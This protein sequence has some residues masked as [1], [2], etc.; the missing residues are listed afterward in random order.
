MRAA[1]SGCWF[2]AMK[3]A[4]CSLCE[5]VGGI[6]VLQT[7]EFRVIR[8]E[9]TDFPAFYRLVWNAHVAEWSDLQPAERARC[10]E[11]VATVERAVREQLAPTKINLAALGN[12]VPHLHWHVVARFE[13]DSHFPAPIWASA[14]RAPN[15]VRLAAVRQ[16]LPDLDARVRQALT[17]LGQAGPGT[18]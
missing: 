12:Q 5:S 8:A 9:E 4:G 14:V 6:L 13:W 17:T 18:V 1:S 16:T 10:M 2:E 15:P 3:Q 7:P 11:A